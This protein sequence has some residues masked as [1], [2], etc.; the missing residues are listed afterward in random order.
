MRTHSIESSNGSAYRSL[1]LVMA[2][3]TFTGCAS[4]NPIEPSPVSTIDVPVWNTVRL[5]QSLDRLQQLGAE[6]GPDQNSALGAYIEFS[7]TGLQRIDVALPAHA[8]LSVRVQSGGGTALI[9]G[10]HVWAHAY[11]DTGTVVVDTLLPAATMLGSKSS[12]VGVVVDASVEAASMSAT[13][14]ALTIALG[15]LDVR[16]S[17]AVNSNRN[18]I[19]MTYSAW[20]HVTALDSVATNRWLATASPLALTEPLRVKT[21]LNHE[22]EPRRPGHL[23]LLPGKDP[24][25]SDEL[26]IVATDLELA[27]AD[28]WIGPALLME[29]ARQSA[30]WT[31]Q[32]LFPRR[33]VL[34]ALWT[35]RYTLDEYLK[36]PYWPVDAT[37]SVL[38][39]GSSSAQQGAGVTIPISTFTLPEEP[40]K[41]SYLQLLDDLHYALLAAVNDM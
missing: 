25:L 12:V 26:V 39:V 23:W 16:R 6:P 14:P 21:H 28:E 13:P 30:L 18:I 1:L 33:S 37:K 10:Y 3:I 19:Q 8:Q 2:A 17:G 24:A 38:Q 7:L 20:E 34:F 31:R 11:S 22:T 41:E 27:S 36:R 40:V 15:R 9:E 29:L 35:D 4:L 32:G 5:Q